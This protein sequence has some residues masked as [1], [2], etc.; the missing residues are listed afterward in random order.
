MP[1]APDAPSAIP[2]TALNPSPATLDRALR[3]LARREH[4]VRELRTKLAAR[5]FADD[6]IACALEHLAGRDLLSDQRFAEAF[7]RS[8]RERGQGPLRIRAQLRQRGVSA[9][10]VSAALDG[11]DIDWDRQAVAARRRRFGPEPPG[12]RS[13]Q[14]RQARFLRGRGFSEGQIARAVLAGGS[15]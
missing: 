4:S 6:D 13:E 1:Q 15:P 8:R 10:L 5:G 9:E 12:S 14:G 3:L 2:A 11:S 7:L